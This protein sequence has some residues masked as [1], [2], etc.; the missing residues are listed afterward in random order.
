MD[1]LPHLESLSIT[2]IGLFGTIYN[3][4]HR[5]EDLERKEAY[6]DYTKFELMFKVN[7]EIEPLISYKNK[8]TG[9]LFYFEKN[10]TWNW[11]GISHPHLDLN[12]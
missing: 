7:T 10:G 8:K 1:Y 4:I 9:E 6:D 5:L 11:Q 2:K 3:Q 12:K